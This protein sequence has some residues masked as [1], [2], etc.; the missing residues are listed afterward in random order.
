MCRT[1]HL[2]RRQLKGK[3][4][5]QPAVANDPFPI[6][7]SDVLLENARLQERIE[8]KSEV[9][10]LMEAA[11]DRQLQDMRSERDFL[12]TDI[13][14]TCS[15]A[16]DFKAVADNILGTFKQIGTKQAGPT[17]SIEPNSIL[18]KPVSPNG[19]EAGEFRP[20]Q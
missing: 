3:S 9:I 12:R 1:Q 20:H 6:P 5:H 8:G 10:R 19:Q 15:L 13:V 14:E 4:R 17:E 7:L 16:R 11:H 2:W 18:Y